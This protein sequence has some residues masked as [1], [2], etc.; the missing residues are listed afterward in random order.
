MPSHAFFVLFIIIIYYTDQNLKGDLISIG[1]P[2]AMSHATFI[3]VDGS[4][5]KI[6][7]MKSLIT[8]FLISATVTCLPAQNLEKKVGHFKNVIASPR[9]NLV[10]VPGETE[11]VKINYINID[12]SKINAYVKNTTL[13]IYLDGSRFTEKRRR[14]K[15]DGWVEKERIYH[16]ASITAYVTFRKLDK[17]VVRGDQEVDVQG[18]VE[19]KKFK[20]IA[21]GECDITLASLQTGKFKASMFGQHTLKI[22]SGVVDTQ[23]YRLFGENKIDAQGIQSAEIASTTYG[24]SKLKFNAKENLR[25]VTFGESDVIVKGGAH[26]NNVA[27]GHSSIN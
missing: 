18:P 12:A 27:F 16:D 5:I 3:T 7:S 15:R 24:E 17:L 4:W 8:V 21:Y 13:R 10:L 25:L 14:L 20:L 2:S 23:K 26:V 1:R 9:I 11:S 22:K 19:N 6:P